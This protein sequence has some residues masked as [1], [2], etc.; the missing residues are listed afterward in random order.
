LVDAFVLRTRF[1]ARDTAGANARAVCIHVL[2][3]ARVMLRQSGRFSLEIFNKYF[4]K[5]KKLC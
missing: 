3:C 5:P 2:H 1:R 4:E